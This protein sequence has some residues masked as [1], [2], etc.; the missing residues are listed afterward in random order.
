MN[1][2]IED[3]KIWERP[4]TKRG[5][6][7]RHHIKEAL[8]LVIDY[9]KTGNIKHAEIKGSDRIV[10]NA[11]ARRLLDASAYYDFI[12]DEWTL[13][14]LEPYR[15][16]IITYFTEKIEVDGFDRNVFVDLVIEKLKELA[17]KEEPSALS[18]YDLL[19]DLI[20]KAGGRIRIENGTITVK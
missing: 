2:R 19:K 14:Y 7:R 6:L 12:K 20:E 10:S 15:D 3:L 1:I 13:G 9:Y 4:G 18:S 5:Y 16:K 8:G 11:E 17:S